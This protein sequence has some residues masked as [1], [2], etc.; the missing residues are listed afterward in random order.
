GAEK[1]AAV[2]GLRVQPDDIVHLGA[3]GKVAQIELTDGA[4]LNLG[5]STRALLQPRFAGASTS[6]LLPIYLGEGWAKLTS[7]PSAPNGRIVILASPRL[8]VVRL[9]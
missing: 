1:F 9:S 4:V 2:P 6:R 8:D 7:A 5:P 3:R